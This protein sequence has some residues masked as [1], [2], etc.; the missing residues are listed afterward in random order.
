M[1]IAES[2]KPA[3]SWGIASCT[4]HTLSPAGNTR[5]PRRRRRADGAVWLHAWF[6]SRVRPTSEGAGAG[7]TVA[8]AFYDWEESQGRRG[9]TVRSRL[10]YWTA[11]AVAWPWRNCEE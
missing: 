3:I 9:A 7:G 2:A 5:K 4:G 8:P 6:A 1:P 11:N 10:N